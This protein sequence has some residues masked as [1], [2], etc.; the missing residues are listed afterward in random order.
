M[1]ALDAA[2]NLLS[3]PIGFFVHLIFY[4]LQQVQ[5]CGLNPSVVS[6]SFSTT[7]K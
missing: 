7:S 1:H 3:R 2:I 6:S 4:V 5:V